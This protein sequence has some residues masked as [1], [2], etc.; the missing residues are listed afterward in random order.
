ME[1]WTKSGRS[2]KVLGL[3][4]G[5]FAF[6]FASVAIAI[7]GKMIFMLVIAVF[8]LLLNFYA[9]KRLNL[10]FKYLGYYFLSL[11]TGK[12]KKAKIPKRYYYSNDN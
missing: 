11:I 7:F 5:L 10:E 8:A 6:L 3:P 1:S 9:K 2:Y 12:R 4:G